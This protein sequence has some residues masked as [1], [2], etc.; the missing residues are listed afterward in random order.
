LRSL[1][2]GSASSFS[3]LEGVVT[4]LFVLRVSFPACG[5]VDG[6]ALAEVF[7]LKELPDF[8]AV[9]RHL[10]GA[11]DFASRL[12]PQG[13][14]LMIQQ[15]AI[16]SLV[17]AKGPS[18]TLTFPSLANLTRAPLAL[19]CSPAASTKMSAF[20]CSLTAHLGD[21]CVVGQDTGFGIVVGLTIIMKRI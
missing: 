5:H 18:I 17:S 13:F 10:C 14:T 2:S 20:R 7:H 1:A 15:P 6:R 16:S 19:A 3:V 12:L 9:S 21:H 4:V 11:G 8:N